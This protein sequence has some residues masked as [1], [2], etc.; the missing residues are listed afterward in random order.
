[1]KLSGCGS[2]KIDF[3]FSEYFLLFKVDNY[4]HQLSFP[5]KGNYTINVIAGGHAISDMKN[6]TAEEMQ[7]Y[8]YNNDSR[9]AFSFRSAS[10]VP[11]VWCF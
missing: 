3:F 4:N 7:L 6:F 9:F 10:V 8:N 5:F 1:M 2:L 11:R